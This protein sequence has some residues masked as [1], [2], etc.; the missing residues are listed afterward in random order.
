MPENLALIF[1]PG[2]LFAL[3]AGR[4]SVRGAFLFAGLFIVL[5]FFL[6]YYALH[7]HGI[8]LNI[9]YPLLNIM[10]ILTITTAYNY[11]F[12]ERYSKRIRSMFSSYVTE[13]VLKELIKNPQMAKLGG[14]RQEIT[15][16]FSDLKGFT[17]F[18]EKYPPEE[19]V[20][21]LNEYLGE[22]TEVI[23]RWEGTLDK[24]MGDAILAFWGAPVKQENH[25]E[26]AVKCAL[27]MV[28]RLKD[29]QDAWAAEGKPVLNAGIGINTGEVLVGNIGAEGKKM[30]YTVIGDHVNLSSRLEALTRKYSTNILISEFTLEKIE[31]AIRNGSIS[32]VA[33]TGLEKVIVKGKEKAVGIYEVRSLEHGQ[34][35]SIVG[36]GKTEVVRY[37]EK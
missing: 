30:D 8:W 7:R 4:F 12:Q 13:T 2:F 22:M 32:H 9:T 19:V 29:L 10:A 36:Y 14:A 25:A 3:T 17:S 15:I 21:I 24:F 28:K 6:G 34:E 16:L 26:L 11:A 20:P 37:K 33:T 1:I 5:V 23:F 31:D 18:S 27:H 35:S